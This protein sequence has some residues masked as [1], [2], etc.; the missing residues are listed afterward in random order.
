M[1]TNSAIALKV[2]ENGFK[3]VYCHWDGYPS[4]N[5]MLL[6]RYYDTKEKI[7]ELLAFGDMSSLADCVENCEF[8]HRDKGEDYEGPH[9]CHSLYYIKSEFRTAQYIY[10]FDNDEWKCYT[11]NGREVSITE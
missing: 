9:N 6:K 7:E 11:P 5:G 4:H 10:V 2:E 1:S 8:Y 3:T